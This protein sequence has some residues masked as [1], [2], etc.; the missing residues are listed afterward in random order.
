MPALFRSNRHQRCNFFWVLISEATRFLLRHPEAWSIRKY[1]LTMP[2]EAADQGISHEPEPL[3]QSAAPSLREF[4]FRQVTIPNTSA[5]ATAG[6]Q[7]AFLS[8]VHQCAQLNGESAPGANDSYQ[9]MADIKPVGVGSQSN[10]PTSSTVGQNDSLTPALS[11]SFPQNRSSPGVNFSAQG[12]D[13]RVSRIV[14]DGHAQMINSPSEKL[15][16]SDVGNQGDTEMTDADKSP[17]SQD[18]S[19]MNGVLP[20]DAGHT[21][22]GGPE[23]EP[24]QCVI[25]TDSNS[26]CQTDGLA[27]TNVHRT[28]NPGAMA[29][30]GAVDEL[31]HRGDST[32]DSDTSLTPEP[33]DLSMDE[34]AEVEMRAARKDRPNY[35][36]DLPSDD[37]GVDG[38]DDFTNSSEESDED[39]EVVLVPR[40]PLIPQPTQATQ[41]PSAQMST[42]GPVSERVII[43]FPEL[44]TRGHLSPS[45]N[46]EGLKY[47]DIFALMSDPMD[48]KGSSQRYNYY[49]QYASHKTTLP[50]GLHPRFVIQEYPNHLQGDV[51]SWISDLPWSEEY[52]SRDML[53]LLPED[54]RPIFRGQEQP[55]SYLQ[56]RQT[57]SRLRV[58]GRAFAADILDRDYRVPP[59]GKLFREYGRNGQEG[60]LYIEKG[61]QWLNKAGRRER[62]NAIRNTPQTQIGHWFVPPDPRRLP[63]RPRSDTSKSGPSTRTR[64]RRE[65]HPQAQLTSRAVHANLQHSGPSSRAANSAV[66]LRQIAVLQ[67]Q[68]QSQLS[69]PTDSYAEVNSST[70][71]ISGGPNSLLI[72]PH[73]PRPSNRD[74]Q[75]KPLGRQPPAALAAAHTSSASPLAR[76]VSAP[77]PQNL[78][79]VFHRC[80]AR[81][82]ISEDC[83]S[84]TERSACLAI[85]RPEPS[86]IYNVGAG[87]LQALA[88]EEITRLIEVTK[89]GIVQHRESSGNT[90]ASEDDLNRLGRHQIAVRIDS[91]VSRYHPHR[92]F[93]L[94]AVANEQQDAIQHYIPTALIEQFDI[95]QRMIRAQVDIPDDAELN[96]VRAMELGRQAAIRQLQLLRQWTEEVAGEVATMLH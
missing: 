44:A 74:R 18:T 30:P 92:S 57:G 67:P 60:A 6:S 68:T 3:D 62:V 52:Q 78:E 59:S 45:G 72:P 9:H 76:H 32:Y 81:L 15:T 46:L 23:M 8:P 48:Y 85:R 56:K 34:E 31:H 82:A 36:V 1:L 25:R 29:G 13:D 80:R 11:S 21:S 41:T 64:S 91:W 86:E 37:E 10:E 84:S 77:S 42:L 49:G 58:L 69:R 28:H 38:D 79:F 66:P 65:L 94:G 5:G 53:R 88:K 71:D 26:T 43:A 16:N 24:R 54:A 83:D 51:I 90:V 12:D 55:H 73:R 4:L 27:T 47:I 63:D 89:L 35:K 61:R 70:Q 75:T 19:S 96:P 87:Q 33:E 95:M 17:S 2:S 39:S 50:Q 22:N 7:N 20:G 40:F 14:E 93:W